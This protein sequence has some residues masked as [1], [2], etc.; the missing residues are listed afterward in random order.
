MSLIS[1]LHQIAS[2]H[3]DERRSALIA[4]L[5]S[6]NAPFVQVYE[7]N[8]SYAP[9]NISVPFFEPGAPHYVIGAH[10]DNVAGS[11]GANDNAAGVCVLLALVNYAL[12]HPLDVPFD[13][14]FFDLEERGMIGSQAYL[15]RCGR[16]SVL[17]MINLDVCGVGDVVL[18]APGPHTPG[19][20]LMDVLQ[21]VEQGGQHP[22]QM[23]ERIP[24]GD[25]LTFERAGLPSVTVCALP[26]G[27]IETLVDMARCIYQRNPPG[28]L[29]PIV[30]TMH[31]GPRDSAAVIEARAMQQVLECII[32]II[33]GLHARR[34]SL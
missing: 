29:P 25:D 27:E 21:A 7:R 6:M 18:A 20:A 19:T 28:V 26:C 31:N 2:H 11:T 14:V 4:T 10:Y 33:E 30:E 32:A 8:G 16:G 13:C 23:V 22:F 34:S 9:E 17:G 3:A 1:W 12:H 5:Q 24:P 15:E